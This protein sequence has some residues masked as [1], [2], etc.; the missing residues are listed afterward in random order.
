MESAFGILF[1]FMAISIVSAVIALLSGAITFFISKKNR[2]KKT[3]LAAAIPFLF[4][5]S[6]YISGLILL[7][8]RK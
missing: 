5:Y 2:K 8:F 1:H 6:L 7:L 4:F 3:F